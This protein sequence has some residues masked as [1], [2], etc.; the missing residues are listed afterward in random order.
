MTAR[1]HFPARAVAGAL[2]AVFT[3]LLAV[4]PVHA[5]TA[6]QL[7][8]AKNDLHSLEQQIADEQAQID[9][10][11]SQALDLASQIDQVQGKQAH[12]QSQLIDLQQQ[13]LDADA[14]MQAT[15]GQLD[16]R[17]RIAYE[18][19]IGS[20]LEFILGSTSLADL[21]MRLQIVD[22]AARSDKDLITD[23][24]GQ[25]VKLQ[26]RKDKLS[27]LEA[28][29][30]S[31]GRDLRHKNDQIQAKLTEANDLQTQL[32]A[33]QAQAEKQVGRLQN[34]LDA[35][36]AAKER[37]RL[38]ALGQGTQTSGGGQGGN[39]VPGMITVCPTPSG[40][41]SDGF[42]A[43]R[44]AGGYHPHA[45]NDMLAPRGAPIYAPFAGS[46]SDSSNGLGGMALKVYGANG[47]V[48]M[49]H[50]SAFASGVVG[51]HVA[52]GTIVGFVGDTGDAP[53]IFHNHFEW[54]PN[55]IPSNP[56]VSA[57]GYT[58]IGSAVDPYPYLNAVC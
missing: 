57:Y 20:N 11:R 40:V 22:N 37:A 42:G 8:G 46:V 38:A 27:G 12:T 43:P 3:V 16:T 36:E 10:L 25:Q 4:G 1:R 26:A 49:A 5:D 45:G 51:R 14:Q 50:M 41:Y 18:Q 53:G 32:D 13:I 2:A 6:S 21:N 29:L 9:A 48:Y 31:Q 17:A 39:W 15:Q 28:D 58:V 19:G 34:K 54:H 35:E 24:Q 44:Y 7:K 56:W 23:I 55:V 33:D 47:W 30:V 52:A